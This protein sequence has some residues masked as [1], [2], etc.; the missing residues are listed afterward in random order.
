MLVLSRKIGERIQIGPD[1]EITVLR[2]TPHCVRIGIVAKAHINIFRSE[3]A[4]RQPVTPT[5]NLIEL[6]L[7]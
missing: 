2:I 3:L 7:A 5:E 1:A 4:E 6:A